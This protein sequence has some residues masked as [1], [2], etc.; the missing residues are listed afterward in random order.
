MHPFIA[1]LALAGLVG[2]GWLTTLQ[3]HDLAHPEPPM[4]QQRVTTFRLVHAA[5]VREKQ[6]N[7]SLIGVFAPSLPDFLTPDETL[8]SCA[9]A[10]S[11]ATF[12]LV[13]E[14]SSLLAALAE[15]EAPSDFG[16]A[17]ETHILTPTGPR[18]APCLLPAGAIVLLTKVLP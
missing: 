12:T 15:R 18:A 2:V 16:R 1:L 3:R 10:R 4:T 11:V 14:A 7:V 13:P 6:H 5:A 17:V 8:F 9:D